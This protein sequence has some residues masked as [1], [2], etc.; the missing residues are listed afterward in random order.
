MA[1]CNG[2]KKGFVTGTRPTKTRLGDMFI[3]V[4]Y[5]WSQRAADACIGSNFSFPPKTVTPL[6]ILTIH[7]FNS[8]QRKGPVC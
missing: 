5:T 6:V 8:H 2:E 3:P 1:W 4:V 7:D